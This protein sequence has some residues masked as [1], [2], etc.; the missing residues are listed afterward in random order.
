MNYMSEKEFIKIR[1]EDGIGIVTVDHPPV[2]ALNSSV[3]EQLDKA[4]DQVAEN[5]EVIGIVITGGGSQLRNITE[6]AQEVFEQ[7]VIIGYPRDING[8]DDVIKN[9]RYST[10]IGLIKYGLEF[11][12]SENDGSKDNIQSII[13]EF[14][15]KLKRLYKKWY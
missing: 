9:P 12:E 2:N 8:A 14:L 6:L 3:L 4:I 13:K 10:A 7:N 15:L 1:T 5:N 11:S